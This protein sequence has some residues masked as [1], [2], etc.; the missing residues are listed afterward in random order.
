M[1]HLTSQQTIKKTLRVKSL[2]H[3]SKQNDMGHI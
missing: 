1:L 3:N 2:N